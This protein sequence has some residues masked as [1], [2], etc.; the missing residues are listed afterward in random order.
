MGAL[1]CQSGRGHSGR[2][3]NANLIIL[4]PHARNAPHFTSIRIIALALY[5][6]VPSAFRS[7]LPT[8]LASI[9]MHLC[10]VNS[11]TRTWR[12]QKRSNKKNL[13]D[14]RASRNRSHASVSP[15]A[16]K[17]N[18][19]I[20]RAQFLTQHHSHLATFFFIFIRE[21]MAVTWSSM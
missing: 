8:T 17:I 6:N 2:K 21:L 3:S 5:S 12:L 20:A 15:R 11:V 4:R 13:H 19:W 10:Y 18:R 7:T 9:E 14:E 16:M 1:V